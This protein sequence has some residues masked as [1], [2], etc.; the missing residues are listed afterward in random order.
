MIRLTFSPRMRAGDSQIMELN[1][2]AEG[3]MEESDVYETY[4]VIAE[5]RLDLAPSDVRPAELLSAALVRGSGAT[6][7]WEVTPREEGILR[8]TVWLYL[9]FIP[10]AGGEETRQPVYA[11]LVEV[12]S[13][14]MLMQTGSEARLLGVVGFGIGVGFCVLLLWQDRAKVL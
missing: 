7:Y 8:G 10:K 13:M 1:V 9:R 5:A 2:T 11:P 4:N 14:S 6:F 12:R 3:E